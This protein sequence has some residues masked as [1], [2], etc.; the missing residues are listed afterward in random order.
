RTRAFVGELHGGAPRG[1][2]VLCAG[3][4]AY[5]YL[6]GEGIRRF[7]ARGEARLTLL[8]R[9]RE[10]TIEA[11]LGGEAQVGVASLDVVP[12]GPIADPLTEGEQAL[13]LPEAHP[14][15]RK[16][17]ARLA[18]LAG[19]RLVVPGPDRPHRVLLARALLEQGIDWEVAVEA[20]GWELMIR[21]VELGVGLAV[22]NA[23]CRLPAGL[24]ARPIA[25][26]PRQRYQVLRRRGA[27]AGGAADRLARVLVET[28]AA[29]RR[30]R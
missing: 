16:R 10:G 4:G 5:L 27:P 13:G 19:A 9:D 17:T 14:L 20:N 21:F 8:T 11:V 30:A 24:C 26:L 1:P 3:E 23:C 2:V 18:D 6:L 25:E 7:V 15:A 22:V 28:G 12:D 29:W